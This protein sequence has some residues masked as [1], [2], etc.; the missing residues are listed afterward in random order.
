MIDP[1]IIRK[2]FPI[3]TRVKNLQSRFYIYSLCCPKIV[4]LAPALE[5]RRWL[6][7]SNHV[8]AMSGDLIVVENLNVDGCNTKNLTF[9]NKELPLTAECG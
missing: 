9:H 7:A 1:I 6:V 8:R 4:A 2:K 3:D 5:L